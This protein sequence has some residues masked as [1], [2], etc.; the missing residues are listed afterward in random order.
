MKANPD[1]KAA[2][3]TLID[4]LYDEAIEAINNKEYEKAQKLL[5]RILAVDPRNKRA[6]EAMM[7]IENSGRSEQLYKEGMAAYMQGRHK[8]AV[9]KFQAAIKYN[10][11]NVK[12]KN[13]LKSAEK[14]LK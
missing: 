4:S 3:K 7:G 1:N 11:N 5:K 14:E 8:E 2:K 13:A 10:P 6:L 12:A 9:L